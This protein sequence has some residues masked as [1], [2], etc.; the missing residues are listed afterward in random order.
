MNVK[1]F[2]KNK[3][4]KFTD[5][6]QSVKGIISTIYF[7]MAAGLVIFAVYLSFKS[8][9]KGSVSVGALGMT[10]FLVSL[11]GFAMGLYSFKED[12]VFL[13]FPWIGTVGNVI[14]WLFV[15]GA[16]LVGM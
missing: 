10:G 8:G 6:R 5:K 16:M 11:G 7:I 3:S 12:N 1:K 9:G 4:Y 13:K 2:I 14:V 15:L